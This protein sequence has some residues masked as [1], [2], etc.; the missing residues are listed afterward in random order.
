MAVKAGLSWNS[1]S[2]D[3]ITLSIISDQ[4]DRRKQGYIADGIDNDNFEEYLVKRIIK[5]TLDYKGPDVE[6][7]KPINC[8]NC[9]DKG[10][11]SLEEELLQLNDL[12][13][14][15]IKSATEAVSKQETKIWFG[16]ET[17]E[18]IEDTR[19]KPWEQK[20]GLYKRFSISYFP[21]FKGQCYNNGEIKMKQKEDINLFDG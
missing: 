11:Y 16:K 8:L 12:I 5:D 18:L 4:K 10:P 2:A 17:A 13:L 7:D 14:G 9:K 20:F 3:K 6:I 21:D 15:S 19:L 1:F